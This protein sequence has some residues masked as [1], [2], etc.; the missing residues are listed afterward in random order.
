MYVDSVSKTSSA[1]GS[2]AAPSA[3]QAGE[4]PAPLPDPV[5]ALATSGDVGAEIAALAVQSG[6]AQRRT[7]QDIRDALEQYVDSQENH[8]IEA[9]RAKARD[10]FANSFIEGAGMAANGAFGCVGASKDQATKSEWAGGGM[11]AQGGA[12]IGSAFFAQSMANDD[13]DATSH[14]SSADRAKRSIQDA[15]DAFKGAGDYV[16]AAI[17]FY[18][19]Y[20]SAQGQTMNAA[21][22]RA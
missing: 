5:V 4:G 16:N 22:H 21:L 8:Q 10:A 3:N 15:S 13:A 7:A 17:E 1:N 9:M 6:D 11:L 18:R 12:K 19:E 14:S 20:V 2:D